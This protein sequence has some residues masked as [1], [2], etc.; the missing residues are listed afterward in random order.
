[1]NAKIWSVTFVSSRYARA[2]LACFCTL[3]WL[4][5]STFP[6]LH[7]HLPSR[8][9]QYQNREIIAQANLSHAECWLHWHKCQV[10]TMSRTCFVTS[11]FGKSSLKNLL[12]ALAFARPGAA[13][14]ST[15]RSSSLKAKF[16][17]TAISVEYVYMQ[18]FMRQIAFFPKDKRSGYMYDTFLAELK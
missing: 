2:S 1:M 11:S 14:L 3:Y 12:D 9:M 18:E 6:Y 15:R 7:V 4:Y 8:K 10:H 17:H 16:M 13:S 5:W